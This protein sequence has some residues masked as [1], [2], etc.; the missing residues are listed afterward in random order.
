MI[1]SM[2][3]TWSSM[4]CFSAGVSGCFGFDFKLAFNI[5]SSR[6]IGGFFLW[7]IGLYLVRVDE[8]LYYELFF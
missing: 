1:G 7:L 4:A 2:I 3:M 5:S 8:L 6:L